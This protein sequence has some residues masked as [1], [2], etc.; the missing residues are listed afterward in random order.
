MAGDSS[1]GLRVSTFLGRLQS[2]G[3]VV[4]LR[5]TAL[6]IRPGRPQLYVVFHPWAAPS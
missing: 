6:R 3:C 1:I 2:A 4:K 5:A